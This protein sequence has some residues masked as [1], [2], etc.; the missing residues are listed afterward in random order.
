MKKSRLNAAICIIILL[1]FFI[2]NLCIHVHA[3]ELE[4]ESNTYKYGNPFKFEISYTWTSEGQTIHS[5]D[6]SENG[7]IAIAFSNNTIGVFDYDMNFL[8]QLSFETNGASGVLWLDESLLF[9]DV[10]SE[11]AIVCDNDGMPEYFY[12]IKGPIN[13]GYEIM[14]KR[15]R[16]QGTDE[17]YCIKRGG[18][19][20]P[21]I[22]YGY[23]TMLKRSS[24]NGKEE[25]L[26]ET[27][28]PADTRYVGNWVFIIG[29]VIVVVVFQ[30]YR[31]RDTP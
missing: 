18:S 27:D 30:I 2:E 12:D 26:Y 14:G 3:A 21:L 13:Y 23:Y 20:D 10:R 31:K 6:V 19:N 1:M 15:S 17:Y 25:I 24:E 5:Y 9:I 7:Q 22:H 8:Y 29:V 11:T 4:L 16:K 28:M